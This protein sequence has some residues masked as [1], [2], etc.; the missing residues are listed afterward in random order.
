MYDGTKINNK[1]HIYLTQ[2]PH[3]CNE[4]EPRQLK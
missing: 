4:A 1:M 2:S 3:M